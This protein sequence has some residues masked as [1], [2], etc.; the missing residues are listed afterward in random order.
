MDA[1]VDF[2]CVIRVYNFIR[3]FIY[4]YKK[5]KEL[6]TV[7]FSLCVFRCLSI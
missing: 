1:Y 2:I 6:K 4:K 3:V 5:T 7:M